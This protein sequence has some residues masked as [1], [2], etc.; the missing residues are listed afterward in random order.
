MTG[1]VE[2][3]SFHPRYRAP[4]L[5]A[6]LPPSNDAKG[7]AAREPARNAA[8]HATVG[9]GSFGRAV[10]GETP[11][12]LH[13]VLNENDWS[14]F[15]PI[16]VRVVEHKIRQGGKSEAADATALFPDRLE[17]INAHARDEW[18]RVERAS[19]DDAAD[20]RSDG[21]VLAGTQCAL[22]RVFVAEPSKSAFAELMG[23]D[24]VGDGG[25]GLLARETTFYLPRDDSAPLYFEPPPNA[26]TGGGRAR[27]MA[28]T[29]GWG[30]T[31]FD[32]LWQEYFDDAEIEFNFWLG[33]D[34]KRTEW[35]P[36]PS[37]DPNKLLAQPVMHARLTRKKRKPAEDGADVQHSEGYPNGFDTLLRFHNID[38]D[39]QWVKVEKYAPGNPEVDGG[40]YGEFAGCLTVPQEAVDKDNPT[41]ELD[42]VT[43][44]FRRA[45]LGVA[46]FKLATAAVDDDDNAAAH[47][48]CYLSSLDTAHP[49]VRNARLSDRTR[50]LS[51]TS[52]WCAACPRRIGCYGG[53][54]PTLCSVA[55]RRL[56]AR[57]AVEVRRWNPDCGGASYRRRRPQFRRCGPSNAPW[58]HERRTHGRC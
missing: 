21:G 45:K 17:F 48:G 5:L 24:E 38:I 1:L 56:S 58:P 41:A 23:D 3:E 36:L 35:G 29:A 47:A 34:R 46:Y 15:G 44:K 6:R 10:V 22:W 11:L 4:E 32:S 39:D 30:D 18:V 55:A 28:V 37:G 13:L 53:R 20:V 33:E 12:H 31:L 54:R 40:E 43:C 52:V 57:L 16:Q 49:Q 14:A 50:F 2:R 42:L 26:L 51:L 7:W 27:S 9:D 8:R 19:D 25:T